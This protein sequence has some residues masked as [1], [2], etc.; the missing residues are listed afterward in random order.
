MGKQ[1]AAGLKKEKEQEKRIEKKGDPQS[2]G[3]EI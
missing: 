2:L 3:K 1:A